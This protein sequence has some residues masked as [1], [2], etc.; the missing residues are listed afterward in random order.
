MIRFLCSSCKMTLA[1]AD[2]RAGRRVKCPYCAFPMAVPRD[3]GTRT[4]P[5]GTALWQRPVVLGTLLAFVLGGLLLYWGA[6]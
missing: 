4:L 2:N 6:R 3:A 1:A 5:R